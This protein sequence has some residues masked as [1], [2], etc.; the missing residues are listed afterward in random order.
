MA[1]RGFLASNAT[2]IRASCPET[3]VLSTII[4]NASILFAKER[5]AT[6]ISPLEL[7]VAV[8]TSKFKF[9][10]R[11]CVTSLVQWKMIPQMSFD[12][13]GK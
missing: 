11:F 10:A 9:E 8:I 6:K 12:S 2:L 13:Y 7:T 1:I 5:A 3:T 4:K